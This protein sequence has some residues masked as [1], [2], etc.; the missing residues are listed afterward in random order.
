ETESYYDGPSLP[1]PVSHPVEQTVP[2]PADRVPA[3][4]RNHLN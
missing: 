2:G 3:D 1:P 4:W